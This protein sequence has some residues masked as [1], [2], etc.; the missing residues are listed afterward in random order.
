M[1]ELSWKERQDLYPKLRPYT[2]ACVD[3]FGYPDH[4]WKTEQRIDEAIYKRCTK[5]SS[6]KQF[7]KPK[8]AKA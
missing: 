3:K 2:K 7:M 5:C 1:K 4:D 8:N 6:V